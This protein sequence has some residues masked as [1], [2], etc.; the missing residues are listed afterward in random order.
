MRVRSVI[1]HA[2]KDRFLVISWF[3]FLITN[4]LVQILFAFQI[5]ASDLNVK[6]RYTAFGPTN[7]YDDAWYYLLS[8]IVFGLFVLVFH[9]LIAAKLYDQRGLHAARIF[10]LLSVVVIVIQY[11]IVQSILQVSLLSR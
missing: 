9:T 6:V 8:F 1:K 11:F 4:L 3:V 2:A 5:K 7:Y 10:I